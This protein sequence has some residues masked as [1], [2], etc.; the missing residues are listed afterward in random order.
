V[1]DTA[2]T[3]DISV[4]DEPIV[5]N[6]EPPVHTSWMDR[7]RKTLIGILSA[8]GIFA[9]S[10]ALTTF[11]VYVGTALIPGRNMSESFLSW[12]SGWY[13]GVVRQ[14]YPHVAY[15]PNIPDSAVNTIAFF[16]LYPLIAR[17]LHNITSLTVLQS[18]IVVSLV[19]GAVATAF[20]WLLARKLTNETT[21]YK[22]VALFSFFP[23]SVG[24]HARALH[25]QRVLHV[26]EEVATR[27][28]AGCMCNRNPTDSN[29]IVPRRALDGRHGDLQ[30]PGLQSHNHAHLGAARHHC[31]LLVPVAP[32]R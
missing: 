4:I 32:H 1:L 20:L 5:I 9:V 7:H 10:R 28:R 18:G 16:P 29:R 15:D 19:S 25:R 31:V 2:V 13:Y 8:I 14:G 12:D 30:V 17:G 6:Y 21:A 24:P 23:G 3:D 26:A 22:A 27:R 11:C